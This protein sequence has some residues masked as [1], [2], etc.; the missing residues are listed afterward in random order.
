M[1][2]SIHATVF[3]GLVLLGGGRS[4]RCEIPVVELNEIIHPV[5]ASYVVRAIESA[6][7]AGAPVVIIRLN[8]PGGLVSSMQV[9]VDKILASRVPVVSFVGPAGAHAASAGFVI[10]ISSDLVA[11]APGTNMGAA[12][13]V[14][15]MGKMEDVES[16]KAASDIAAYVRGKAERRGRD[17]KMAEQAV[18]ES[19]SFTDKEALDLKLADLI[20]KDIPE[21]IA[22]LDG[23]EIKRFDGTKVTLKTKGE[24]IRKVEMDWRQAVLSVLA[25]PAILFLL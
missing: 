5:S 21:L 8:T 23:R 7:A 22:A 9:I 14:G 19:K 3:A 24:T 25:N 16:K 15:G 1:F 11:M 12:H 6:E 13:P 2:K 20:V 17:V 10:A 4:A 18:L